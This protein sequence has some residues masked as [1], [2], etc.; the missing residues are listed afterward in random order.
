MNPTH[1][2]A[3]QLYFVLPPWPASTNGAPFS[4]PISPPPISLPPSQAPQFSAPLHL[5]FPTPVSPVS[6]FPLPPSPPLDRADTDP[7]IMLSG[8]DDV[9]DVDFDIFKIFPSLAEENDSTSGR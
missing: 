5:G 4:P 7:L 9:Q 1:P 2:P 6:S 8:E 3:E